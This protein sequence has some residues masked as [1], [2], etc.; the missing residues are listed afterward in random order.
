VEQQQH[1]SLMTLKLL[2]D[3][4]PSTTGNSIFGIRLVPHL[5]TN[6]TVISAT[7]TAPA[8]INN[9]S[10][11]SVAVV[12]DFL[13]GL[14]RWSDEHEIRA[15]HFGKLCERAGKEHPDTLAS[16]NN[17]AT[18][19]SNQGKYEQ[20]EEIHRQALRLRETVLGKEHPATLG[21]MNNLA[22]V[23]SDQGKYE[24]AEGM[25]RQALKLRETVLGKEHPD[26]LASMN[27][28]AAVLRDQ[29]KYEQAEEI[30]Q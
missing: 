21:S 13:D 30:H 3:I 7:N 11:D 2:I 12:G 19:L 5:M 8:I 15:F 17:L 1:L 4:I 6:F 24:Q 10:L 22:E 26:T 29:G 23:L 25:H 28:L 14:G 9:E 27:N 18:V 20:A 16:M